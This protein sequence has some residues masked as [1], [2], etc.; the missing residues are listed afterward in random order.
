MKN[1]FKIILIAGCFTSN[2]TDKP[3][4]NSDKNTLAVAAAGT[5]VETTGVYQNELQIL[6]KKI[7]NLNFIQKWL[8]EYGKNNF[9]EGQA[10]IK[11]LWK[12]IVGWFIKKFLLPAIDSNFNKNQKN[13]DLYTEFKKYVQ[14]KTD[15]TAAPS[16]VATPPTGQQ[17]TQQPNNT[18]NTAN[19][20]TTDNNSNSNPDPNQLTQENENESSQKK[21]E[22]AARQKFNENPALHAFHMISTPLTTDK[23]KKLLINILTNKQNNP[24]IN[25]SSYIIPEAL[26]NLSD[27]EKK[28]LITE[29][30]KKPYTSKKTDRETTKQAKLTKVFE[31]FQNNIFLSEKIDKNH[32]HYVNETSTTHINQTQANKT[33]NDAIGNIGNIGKNDDDDHKLQNYAYCILI[34]NQTTDEEKKIIISILSNKKTTDIPLNLNTEFQIVNNAS[35]AVKQNF[36]DSF[37]NQRYNLTQTIK[38]K[39]IKKLTNKKIN[40]KNINLKLENNELKFNIT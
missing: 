22:E 30:L 20:S 3:K 10:Q 32:T 21:E 2:T 23:E 17:K 27:K 4:S 19:S 25:V 13:I 9:I 15:G 1:L 5:V 24:E 37:L 35:Y 8:F 12:D 16:S 33:L 36:I 39:F 31:A 38:N 11:S 28:D 18:N 14:Q 34:N 6:E 7:N 29:F 26:K 40:E